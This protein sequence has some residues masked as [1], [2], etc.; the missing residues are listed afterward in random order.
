M[1]INHHEVKKG[2]SKENIESI[3]QL[4]RYNYQDMEDMVSW[5]GMKRGERGMNSSTSDV[6]THFEMRI[7]NVHGQ[8]REYRTTY[9]LC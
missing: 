4:T 5:M 9:R 7:S 8:I 1:Y 3:G 6:H 2:M